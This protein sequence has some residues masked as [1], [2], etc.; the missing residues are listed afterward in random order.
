MKRGDRAFFYHSNCGKQ[1]GIVGTVVITK[2]AHPDVTA[3]EDPNH[4]GYDPKST[5][6][7]CRWDAVSVRLDNIYPTTLT[8][9]ELKTQAKHNNV[10]AGHD[11]VS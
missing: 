8:L 3:Y 4:K 7:D 10:L 11:F 1:V 5:A 2:E 9:K 6:D